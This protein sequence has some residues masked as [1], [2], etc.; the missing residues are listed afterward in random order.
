MAIYFTT[1]WKP[2]GTKSFRLAAAQFVIDKS[3]GN[4][5]NPDKLFMMCVEPRP[6]N[7]FVQADQSG[8]ESKIVA[9]ECEAGRF[10][11]IV[12]LGMKPH[13]YVALQIFRHKFRGEFDEARYWAVDPKVLVTYPEWKKLE[14]TI[15]NST[16]E[17]QLGKKVVHARNYS[18]GYK[19]YKDNVLTESHGDIVLSAAEAKYHLQTHEILFPEIILFQ[20]RIKQE[21]HANRFLF[22]LFGHPRRFEKRMTGDVEREAL[23]FIPQST[24]GEITNR[25]CVTLQEY[26]DGSGKAGRWHFANNKHDSLMAEVPEEDGME[27]AKL[28]VSL[29]SV[30]LTSTTGLKYSMGAEVSIGRN[31]GKYHEEHNPHGM[32]EVDV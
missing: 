24:V 12:D 9:F 19:T 6:G 8:A 14:K 16:M 17:Y 28:L 22:N 10:R 15:K 20:E 25:A 13:V 21:L 2:T 4:A 1:S 23:S 26:I 31:W 11:S 27:C 29:L 18:M 7:V 5:Q 30:P 32:N 3:G